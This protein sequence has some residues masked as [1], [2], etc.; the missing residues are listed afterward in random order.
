MK[1][2]DADKQY[3]KLHTRS[4][5]L[6]A[7]LDYF[8]MEAAG[9]IPTKN[10]PGPI[11]ETTPNWVDEHLGRI[12]EMYIFPAWFGNDRDPSVT[13]GYDE[14]VSTEST[15]RTMRL[16]NGELKKVLIRKRSS[17]LKETL[18]LT[19]KPDFVKNYNHSLLET[20]T[21]FALLLKFLKTPKRENILALY[22]IILILLRGSSSKLKYP[23]E[24]L[25]MLFQQYSLLPLKEACNVL[26]G[27]FVNLQGHKDSHIPSDQ[28]NEWV[29][30]AQ[31]KIIKKT[32]SN[33]HYDNLK[34][35]SAS[36]TGISE[37]ILPL[38]I[39]F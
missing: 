27:C 15:Y 30:K 16:K 9:L 26:Y 13:V 38:I 25:R 33:K 34:K 21:V 20:G 24:I 35:Q 17:K 19:K 37:V 8:G 23:Y 10:I 1:A 3:M 28:Y 32:Y 6:E 11:D 29:V 18:L 36:I 22:K 14:V 2:F 5:M 12:V 4:L 39:F 7:V 31:K